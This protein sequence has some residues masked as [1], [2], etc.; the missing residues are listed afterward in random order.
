[1]ANSINELQ[2]GFYCEDDNYKLYGPFKSMK[3]CEQYDYSFIWE[4]KKIRP[5]DC[6][7]NKIT[8]D[9]FN[10][11]IT[12]EGEKNASIK[13]LDKVLGNGT[14]KF[15]MESWEFIVAK[16]KEVCN[17][18]EYVGLPTIKGEYLNEMLHL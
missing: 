3:E 18:V 9:F 4:L 2:V 16:A 14:Y 8:I 7:I 17:N 5:K 1:M 13:I 15:N 10:S 6:K 11:N 12:I